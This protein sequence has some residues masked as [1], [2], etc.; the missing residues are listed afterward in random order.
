M[1]D[2]PRNAP[3][4]RSLNESGSGTGRSGSGSSGMTSSRNSSLPLNGSLPSIPHTHHDLLPTFRR[5]FNLPDNSSDIRSCQS[6]APEDIPLPDDP[7]SDEAPLSA[8]PEEKDSDAQ[9]LLA[10][11]RLPAHFE[12]PMLQLPSPEIRISTLQKDNFQR[13]FNQPAIRV[14]PALVYQRGAK[15]SISHSIARSRAAQGVSFAPR[16]E[17]TLYCT[18]SPTS[19]SV[20]VVTVIIEEN[21]LNKV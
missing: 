21:G 9:S 19:E 18:E 1:D 10:L 16:I 15:G 5:A 6:R 8:T 14:R 11:S 3:D 13:R 7:F 4:P 2:N 20:S 17:E 12:L